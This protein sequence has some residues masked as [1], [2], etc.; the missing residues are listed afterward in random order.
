M[1]FDEIKEKGKGETELSPP[2]EAEPLS[3]K[4]VYYDRLLSGCPASAGESYGKRH[5]CSQ[6]K[7]CRN[8]GR[9]TE[10]RASFSANQ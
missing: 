10:L 8:R 1:I 9:V 4:T 5:T 2:K 6:L 3:G 7:E